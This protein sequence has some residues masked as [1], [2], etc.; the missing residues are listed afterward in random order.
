MGIFH[1]FREQVQ[2]THRSGKK[3]DDIVDAIFTKRNVIATEYPTEKV[4]Y[5]S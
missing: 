3:W 5:K 4:N 1:K 2:S